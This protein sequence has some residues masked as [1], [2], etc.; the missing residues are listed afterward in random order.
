MAYPETDCRTVLNRLYLFLDG[1]IADE[2]CTV[3][4]IHL[5]ECISCMHQYGFERD[6]KALVHRKCSGGA[7]PGDIAER[8]KANIR[9]ALGE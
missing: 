1:E 2:E 5:E 9:R 4:Q 8:I 6:F 7:V 3:I